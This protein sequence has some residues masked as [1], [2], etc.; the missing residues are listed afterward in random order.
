MVMAGMG[1]DAA[2][3]EGVNEDIKKRVGWLAYVLSGLK[4]LI[5]LP[6]RSS[7]LMLTACSKPKRFSI[8][9]LPADS[10]SSPL[11]SPMV[12]GPSGFLSSLRSTPSRFLS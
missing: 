2:I 9:A 5:W 10:T 12:S 11:R 8:F 4:S 6:F 7:H 1:F 3:M